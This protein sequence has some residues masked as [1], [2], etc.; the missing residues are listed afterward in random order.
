MSDPTNPTD[1]EIK[2][3]LQSIT[4]LRDWIKELYED[5]GKYEDVAFQA[6]NAT[7]QTPGWSGF[8][9]NAVIN[10]ATGIIDAVA[11]ANGQPLVVP[12]VGFLSAE[13]K[14]WLNNKGSRPSNLTDVFVEYALSHL[15]MQ[16][17]MEKQLAHYLDET[18]NHANLRA[19]WNKSFQAQGSTY[20]VSDLAKPEHAFPGIGDLWTALKETAALEF[21]K[22]MWNLIVMKTCSYYRNWS[23]QYNTS[24]NN[25]TDPFDELA[26]YVRRSLYIDHPGVYARRN[27]VAKNVQGGLTIQIDYWNLGLNGNEFPKSVCDLLFR[28]DTV[29]HII[30]PDALFPRDYVFKQFSLTKPDLHQ[31]L[32]SNWKEIPNGDND[33]NFTGGY[34]PELIKH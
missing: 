5:T 24:G 3:A 4:N 18:N 9:V 32:N 27:F 33:W 20:K 34:F 15:A 10:L 11:I 14:E 29:G 30:R 17:A 21:K 16:E 13:I 2:A 1:H 25:G 19:A 7:V 26:D 22:R 6:L 12:A 23:T 28:D 8:I 31:G